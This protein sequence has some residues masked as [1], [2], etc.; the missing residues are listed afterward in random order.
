MLNKNPSQESI[1]LSIFFLISTGEI[2]SLPCCG[3]FS[4]CEDFSHH[5][6]HLFFVYI[7]FS[8]KNDTQIS[9]VKLWVRKICRNYK[10]WKYEPVISSSILKL[11]RKKW[12][13]SSETL[14]T[15]IV[16]VMVPYIL[17]PCLQL[18]P[19][20][21]LFSKLIIIVIY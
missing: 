15:F 21:L 8:K 1:F 3:Y 18:C 16:E 19:C 10:Q 7:V 5:H 13:E 14:V 12:L 6:H 2:R 4:S 20:S 9:K 17:L 11:L